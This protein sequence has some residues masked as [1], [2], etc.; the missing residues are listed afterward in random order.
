LI[1]AWHTCVIATVLFVCALALAPYW[2]TAIFLKS[3]RESFA[4]AF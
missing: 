1:R 4:T 2:D 3:L